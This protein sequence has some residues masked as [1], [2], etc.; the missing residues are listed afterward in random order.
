MASSITASIGALRR[1]SAAASRGLSSPTERQQA[2]R[3]ADE[4]T[5]I[6][7]RVLQGPRNQFKRGIAIRA[8]PCAAVPFAQGA[9]VGG[10]RGVH[11]ECTLGVARHGK[12]SVPEWDRWPAA[13]SPRFAGS[14]VARAR[15]A[16]PAGP[17]R[18]NRCANPQWA[19][20]PRGRRA[21]PPNAPG[22]PRRR[23]R[24]P[25]RARSAAAPPTTHS[26]AS[27]PR[28]IAAGTSRFASKLP[29]AA[30]STPLA[31][32]ATPRARSPV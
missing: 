29:A 22:P 23:P 2:L 17:P 26:L 20:T 19:M 31:W 27:K 5:R 24:A 9:R 3:P 12:S 8:P 11:G 1:A 30:T 14:S 13:R 21:G 7:W 25:H 6:L 32:P 4:P 10:D 15:S 28:T 16:L 18:S